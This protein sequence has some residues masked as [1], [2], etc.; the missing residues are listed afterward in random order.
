MIVALA[1]SVLSG[2]GLVIYLRGARAF[3]VIYVLINL[4]LALAMSFM[5][6]MAVTGTWL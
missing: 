6:S 5:A 2:V 3:A 1:A 4:F